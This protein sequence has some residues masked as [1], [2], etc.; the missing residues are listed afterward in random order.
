MI[1]LQTFRDGKAKF[2]HHAHR[3]RDRASVRP[4]LPQ[5]LQECI[6]GGRCSKIA[7]AGFRAGALNPWIR[8]FGHGRTILAK[9][10]PIRGPAATLSERPA[11]PAVPSGMW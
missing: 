2:A 7:L 4:S 11:G 1:T 3:H 5:C 8:T 6:R 9:P 10:E